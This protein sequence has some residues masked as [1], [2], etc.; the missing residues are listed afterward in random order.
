METIRHSLLV[1]PRQSVALRFAH[2]FD[3]QA[4]SIAMYDLGRAGVSCRETKPL[5]H[6]ALVPCAAEHGFTTVYLED[7]SRWGGPAWLETRDWR[8]AEVVERVSLRHERLVF[9]D[10][11]VSTDGRRI[12]VASFA[13]AIRVFDCKSMSLAADIKGGEM[14]GGLSFSPS[15]RRLAAAHMYQG[16][17]HVRVHDLD[18]DGAGPPVDIARG[19]IEDDYVSA[20]TLFAGDD[21]LIVYAIRSFDINGSVARYGLRA[22]KPLWKCDMDRTEAYHDELERLPAFDQEEFGNVVLDSQLSLGVLGKLLLVGSVGNLLLVDMDHGQPAGTMETT[23][24]GFITQVRV[25]RDG[26]VAVLDH[27]GEVGIASPA[28]RVHTGY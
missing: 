6:L 13:Q 15:G 7:P 27:L 14:I 22:P 24:K 5:D 2:N 18:A 26:E 23:V 1:H 17:G 9:Q 11:A 19:Q 25:T 28:A 10:C 21:E 16:S 8:T 20:A 12:A 4:T 3:L